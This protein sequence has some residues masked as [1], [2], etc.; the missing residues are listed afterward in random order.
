MGQ[1]DTVLVVDDSEE[2]RTFVTALLEDAGFLVEQASDG[3]EALER[4]RQ[5]RPDLIL[6]DVVMPRMDGL[7]LLLRLRSDLA[8]PIPPV[9][10]CSGFD[11]TEEE[12][13]RRG[14]KRFL[15]KPIAP[16][17]LLQ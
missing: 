7:D 6:L 4:A 8:P 1:P 13:L 15:R 3:V 12:A 9:I 14:A 2:L 10:L 11:L 17:D 16:A 5:R